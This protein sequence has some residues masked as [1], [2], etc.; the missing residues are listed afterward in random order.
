MAGYFYGLSGAEASSGR[1]G[2]GNCSKSARRCRRAIA[3]QIERT[4]GRSRE[5][6]R[7]LFEI[8]A[9]L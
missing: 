2:S 9:W 3:R 7:E 8:I 4:L 1:N 6:A 5:E